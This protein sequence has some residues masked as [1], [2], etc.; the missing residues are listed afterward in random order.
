MN[1]PL[2]AP[3]SDAALTHGRLLIFAAAILWST[4]GFFGKILTQPTWFALNE[5]PI[6]PLQIA[7]FR[8]FFAG[9]FLVLMLKRADLTIKPSMFAMALCF[10][11][12]NA[13]F[14]IA[15]TQGTAANA[16]LLQYTA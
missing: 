15:L 12:M 6:G 11:A 10:A 7:F 16:I 14:I 8:L 13:M 2:T 4:N 3:N 9:L 1:Q 5:P